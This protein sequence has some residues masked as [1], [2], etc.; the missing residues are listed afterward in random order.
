MG[1]HPAAQWRGW[2]GSGAEGR[3]SDAVTGQERRPTE[4]AVACVDSRRRQR[5]VLQTLERIRRRFLQ[6]GMHA[7]VA[8]LT[9]DWQLCAA[10][11]A[12]Q[13]E[14]RVSMRVAVGLARF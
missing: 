9:G 6:A 13:T 11:P 10:L 12:T 2:P 4:L 1:A 14:T 8:R 3:C 7:G 5:R